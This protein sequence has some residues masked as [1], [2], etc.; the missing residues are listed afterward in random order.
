M[1][2]EEYIKLPPRTAE[3]GQDMLVTGEEGK[4]EV[5]Q[6]IPVEEYRPEEGEMASYEHLANRTKKEKG[7]EDL[8]NG[9]K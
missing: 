2:M 1:V 8:G 9:T 5:I 7:E 6:L 3:S 4:K